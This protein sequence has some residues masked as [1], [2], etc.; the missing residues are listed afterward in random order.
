MQL[1]WLAE[2][3]RKPLVSRSFRK[4]PG[5]WNRLIGLLN[6]KLQERIKGKSSINY[7]FWTISIPIKEN[8]FFEH[9][10]AETFQDREKIKN[11]I[12]FYVIF[13]QILWLWYF[14]VKVFFNPLIS[15]PTKWSSTLKQ[16]VR[17]CRLKGYIMFHSFIDARDLDDGFCIMHVRNE[18]I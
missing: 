14:Q 3:I 9:K 7:Q 12:S 2:N 8:I 1:D 4:S 11:F 5:E 13:L 18:F 17:C 15:I 10:V 6:T 16:F